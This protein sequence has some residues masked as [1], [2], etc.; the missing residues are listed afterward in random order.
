MQG[1]LQSPAAVRLAFCGTLCCL[2][3][4]A[5]RCLRCRHQIQPGGAEGNA[6]HKLEVAVCQPQLLHAGGVA[7]PSQMPNNWPSCTPWPSHPA[8]RRSLCKRSAA[9]GLPQ[10]TA[11]PLKAAASGQVLTPVSQECDV[12]EDEEPDDAGAAVPRV[13]HHAAVQVVVERVHLLVPLSQQLLLQG[14]R[15]GHSAGQGAVVGA[16]WVASIHGAE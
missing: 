16:S 10:A 12:Q 5:S 3:P 13:A 9:D 8:S 11:T 4:L 7:L 14:R 2:R 6:V 1:G 15:A